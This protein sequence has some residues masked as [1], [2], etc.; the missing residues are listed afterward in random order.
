MRQWDEMIYQPRG[1]GSTRFSFAEIDVP[2]G[3][4]ADIT[5]RPRDVRFTLNSGHSSE[6]QRSAR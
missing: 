1:A 4:K 3:S 2:F 6:Y 5:T